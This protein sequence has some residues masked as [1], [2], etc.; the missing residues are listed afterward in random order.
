MYFKGAILS[1]K[2]YTCQEA[3]DQLATRYTHQ[4][5]LLLR[6]KPV[7]VLTQAPQDIDLYCIESEAHCEIKTISNVSLCLIAWTR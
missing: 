1:M 4:M 6:L 3:Q 2:N 7:L 5:G